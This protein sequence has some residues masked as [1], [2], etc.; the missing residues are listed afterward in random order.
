MRYS[1]LVDTYR[2]L[3]ST[4][5][6][7]EKRD[8]L[9]SLYKGS[10]ELYKAVLL[11]MGVVI[12]IE[13]IGIAKEL[14]K[15][16][17]IKA[18]GIDEKEFIKRFK[19]TGDLGL[20][21]EFFSKNRKQKTFS[22]KELTIDHVFD[23]IKNLSEITGSGS[24][25]RKISLIVELLS[26]ADPEEAK[27]IIRT[28]I[29]DMRIGVSHGIVRDAIAL[30]FDK[31]TNDIEKAWDVLGDLGKVAE[32]ARKGIL[33]TEITLFTPIRVMLAD[34]AKNLKEAINV[35]EHP[36]IEVKYDG[37]RIQIHKN[38]NIIRLFSRR[39]DDVTN[40]FP[41]IVRLCK[42]NIKAR[43][44]I[45]EGE[46]LAV[47]EKGNAKPFQQLSRRIQ[48]KHDIEKTVK[49]IPVQ[50]NLFDMIYL[51]G[52]NWMNKLLKERW[53][54]LNEIITT[55]KK[56]FQLAVHIETD[57]YKEAERFYR[58]A[59]AAG[60]EGVIVKNMDAYYQPGRRVGFWLKVKD[61]LEPL[62]LVIV[63]AEWG[64]GKRAN[65]FGSLLIAAKK[66][67]KY[68]ETGMLGSGLTENQL[69]EM[70]RML[71]P[72]VVKEEGKFAE[73]KPRIVVEV[74][75]EEIQKSP[76]YPTG[77]ALRFPRLLRIRTDEK[78]PEDINTVKDIEKLFYNQRGKV[79]RK[80]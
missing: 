47:D 9:S 53:Y 50:V 11:S 28:I 4:T 21:A 40:Q 72:L 38:G 30:A 25:D 13:Q 64:E 31:K 75:Y 43:S 33:N 29:G 18:Y 45:V 57:N 26:H 54:K 41:D 73:V 71:K 27:Y 78:K 61:I 16:T 49:Q 35:F 60:D 15:K 42:D 23:N 34:R 32:M 62:D 77:Y 80:N 8:I 7:L 12:T 63:G 70:T 24:Q 59:L 36:A 37:F 10:K 2:K 19:E 52:E 68:L 20:C 1:T 22:K 74:G 5:K 6:K 58:N 14:L 67:D 46:V 48:R 56:I 69:E 76:K 66:D 39:L 55:K 65:W 3:E 51:N 44:C 17:I 79:R